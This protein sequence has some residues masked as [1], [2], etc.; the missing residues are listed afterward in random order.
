M[1]DRFLLWE[2]TTKFGI[3]V[4]NSV[5]KNCRLV[6]NELNI[7]RRFCLM[8]VW[9]LGPCLP[10]MKYFAGTS[11]HCLFLV[12]LS[13][14]YNSYNCVWEPSFQVFLNYQFLSVSPARGGCGRSLLSEPTLLP[15][16]PL[17]VSLI[18]YSSSRAGIS[19]SLPRAVA[20]YASLCL[21][22]FFVF[23]C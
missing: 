4:Q 16:Y 14:L 9:W 10:Q 8:Y 11:A 20:K 19:F 7:V 2:T 21:E 5:S 15:V 12:T 3:F 1:L 17:R 22:K 18:Y 23:L 6:K 13:G